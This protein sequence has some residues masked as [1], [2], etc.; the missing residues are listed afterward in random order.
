MCTQRF[1]DG[2]DD[3]WQR[4]VIHRWVGGV[5]NRVLLSI[6]PLAFYLEILYSI[7]IHFSIIEGGYMNTRYL[8]LSAAITGTLAALLTVTP[9]ANLVNCLVC[10]WLWIGGLAA[11]WMYRENTGEYVNNRDGI[12]LGLLSGLFGAA[13]ATILSA[14]TGMSAS[15]PI[16]A[17]QLAQIEQQFG[18]Q[19]AS[20]IRLLASPATSLTLTI[21]INLVIYSLFGLIGGLIGAS[22]FKSKAVS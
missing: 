20:Y 18:E 6:F 11:V 16:P 8:L 22:V 15:T 9:I 14:V 2:F 17:A 10:G 21:V 12:I 13:V 7:I 5:D 1:S 4:P 19:A 3:C